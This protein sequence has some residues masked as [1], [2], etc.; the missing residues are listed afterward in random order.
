MLLALGYQPTDASRSVYTFDAALLVPAPI[1][2]EAAH[3]AAVK[4]AAQL[5]VEREEAGLEEDDPEDE[6]HWRAATRTYKAGA[7]VPAPAFCAALQL[8]RKLLAVEMET[9][10]KRAAALPVRIHADHD[11]TACAAVG[12][13]SDQGM[14]HEME[15]ELSVVWGWACVCV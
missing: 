6:A 2:S 1:I 7:T 3:A 8:L 10:S 4:A 12:V 13:A 9:L 5:R 15:V 11:F 14:R